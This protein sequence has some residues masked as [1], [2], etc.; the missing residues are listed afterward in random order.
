MQT[1][2]TGSMA[3]VYGDFYI[4]V[5][6]QV[7]L[8]CV[9]SP[10]QI[11]DQGRIGAG[12]MASIHGADMR[13]T[14]ALSFYPEDCEFNE[15]MPVTIS[16]GHSEHAAGVTGKQKLPASFRV[17]KNG[18]ITRVMLEREL[19]VGAS[20]YEEKL[21]PGAAVAMGYPLEVRIYVP[22][23]VVNITQAREHVSC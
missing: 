18:N 23:W 22:L 4:V 16:K 9:D 7:L 12:E 1:C 21:D 3:C 2:D 8:C 19:D 15:S 20:L 5:V 13:S 14:V 10:L 6:S 11:R 17:S